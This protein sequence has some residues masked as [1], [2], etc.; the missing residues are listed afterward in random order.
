[1]QAI[2]IYDSILLMEPNNLRA[3]FNKGLALT[4]EGKYIEADKIFKK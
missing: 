1:M 4:G 3:M 2:S